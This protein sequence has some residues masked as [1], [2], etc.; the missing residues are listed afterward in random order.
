MPLVLFQHFRGN[1][2]YWDP[3][4]IDALASSRRV[5]TFDNAGVGG[6]TG[7]TPST[8]E[9]MAHDAIAF[10]SA[11]EFDQVDAP[12]VLHRQL[13]RT[14][15]GADPVRA[16]TQPCARVLG[17]EGRC[18]DARLGARGDRC[19]RSTGAPPQRVPPCVLRRV[20]VESTRRAGG[21]PRQS[22]SP[23]SGEG[24]CFAMSTRCQ[25][26]LLTAPLTSSRIS[27]A[28]T[29]GCAGPITGGPS[30][31]APCSLTL[32]SPTRRARRR[33]A[34]IGAGDSAASVRASA[35]SGR[36]PRRC[37]RGRQ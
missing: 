21:A 2:D 7:T 15:S 29:G 6:S 14:G 5:V 32:G 13:R 33:S 27:A 8:V 1:L 11:V 10:L 26:T 24:F 34:G 37:G 3:A 28:S 35:N 22:L 36:L 18:R 25:R 16:C 20:R 30:L 19:R 9:E 4:L 23:A 31:G 17:A 12:R